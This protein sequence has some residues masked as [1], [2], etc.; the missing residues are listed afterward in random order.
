MYS[1]LILG[2]AA[3]LGAMATISAGNFLAR[4]TKL[5]RVPREILAAVVGVVIVALY[6]LGVGFVLYY[7][8]YVPPGA[9]DE[10]GAAVLFLV[11]LLFGSCSALFFGISMGLWEWLKNR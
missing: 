6:A 9:M 1:Y 10:T 11:S 4:R 7:R 5:S 3:A 2:F 8:V